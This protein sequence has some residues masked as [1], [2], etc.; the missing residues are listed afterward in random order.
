MNLLDNTSNQPSKFMTI[1]WAEI[2]DESCGTCSTSMICSSLC[3]KSDA[4]IYV[5]GTITIPNTTAT[6]PGVNNAN[7]KVISKN[8]ASFTNCISEINNTK[9]D[10]AHDID[11]EM[12]MYNLIE[13]GDIYSKTS[14]S[15]W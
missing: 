3:D 7:K 2:K 14:G 12:R 5:I 4:Y 11:V 15:S 1:N 10:D 13:H 6:S 8:C 9:V